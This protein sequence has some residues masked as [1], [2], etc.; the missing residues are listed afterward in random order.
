M[1]IMA[2]P[3]SPIASAEHARPAVISFGAIELASVERGSPG[4]NSIVLRAKLMT[5]L[6][7]AAEGAPANFGRGPFEQS[8]IKLHH[9]RGRET[10]RRRHR[11]P[12]AARSAWASKKGQYLDVYYRL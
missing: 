11:A 2:H 9:S 7:T 1:S 3:L 4:R 8:P 12:S 5:G 6:S 10:R